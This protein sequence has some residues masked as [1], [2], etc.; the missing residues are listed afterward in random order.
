MGDIALNSR[1]V[2]KKYAKTSGGY[3]TYK[4]AAQKTLSLNIDPTSGTVTNYDVF[5]FPIEQF[6]IA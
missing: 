5:S 2:D 1:Y 3:L 4:A 6:R